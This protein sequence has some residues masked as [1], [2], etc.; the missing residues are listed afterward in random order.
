MDLIFE[1]SN[2]IL[3]VFITILVGFVLN[4]LHFFSES[5]KDEIIKLVFYVGTPCLIFDSIASADLSQNLN[6][7]YFLFVAVLI[8]VLIALVIA[9]C[10]F[11]KDKKKKGA[12]IQ[13]AYRSNF[14]IAG[15]PIAMNLLDPAGVTLT[16]VTMSMV[17]ILYNI[18]AVMILSYYGSNKPRPS[19]V[20]LGVLKNPLIIATVFSLLFALLKLPVFP[21]VQKSVKTLGSIASSMGLVLIGAS[22]T[23]RGFREDK[24]YI[25]FAAFLRN[26]FAPAFILTVAALF[27]YRGNHLLVLAVMS[28]SPAAVNCFPMAKQMGVSAE[29]SAYGISITSILS[30]F[31]I[32]ISVY[33]IQFLGLA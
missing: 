9:L 12:V 24:I 5:T 4:K 8:L 21:V 26:I 17:I 3:P 16:A 31:S 27:G 6:S 7:A 28:A 18:T 11:I 14:A 29:I 32:F 25:L 10:F 13:L 30:I 1:T 15:M 33:L 20:V 22:I 2:A 19:T 23:L